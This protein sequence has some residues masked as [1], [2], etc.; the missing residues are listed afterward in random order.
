MYGPTFSGSFAYT[1]KKSSYLVHHEEFRKLL[2]FCWNLSDAILFPND[3][4]ERSKKC[5]K[6]RLFRSLRLGP[7]FCSI[8]I[9]MQMPFSLLSEH[10]VYRTAR[11]WMDC[12]GSGLGAQASARFHDLTL[13]QN[14][15]AKLHHTLGP[16]RTNLMLFNVIH[17]M[18]KSQR[19]ALCV[20]CIVSISA[21]AVV[22]NIS[23]TRVSKIRFCVFL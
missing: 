15:R 20:M 4:T 9:I 16:V 17:K 7:M 3:G 6:R 18:F 14:T 23:G 19:I 1:N 11:I 21:V 5:D 22:F 8:L 10:Y 13:A 2:L 12:R